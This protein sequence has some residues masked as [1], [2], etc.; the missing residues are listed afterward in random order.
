MSLMRLL[1]AGKSLVGMSDANSR[2]RMGKPGMMPKFGSGRNPFRSAAQ[3]KEGQGESVTKPVEPAVTPSSSQ[4]HI[5]MAEQKAQRTSPRR[6]L[7]F[8]SL[9]GAWIEK[10]KARF[11]RR[12]SDNQRAAIA[13]SPSGLMQ[14]ELSLDR[15]KVVRNDLSDTDFEITARE[16]AAPR[17]AVDAS[18]QEFRTA[19]KAAP[20][21]RR[22]YGPWRE[23]SGRLDELR[24]PARGAER[25]PASQPIAAGAMLSPSGAV[26]FA[27]V[28]R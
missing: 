9:F 2:Y 8:R 6:R 16:A 12:A 27:S 15:I 20:T 3:K 1:S 24:Q 19:M 11:G 26:W 7:V 21:A 25:S 17:P 4:P 5:S 10:L 13:P 23:L 14:G 18:S 28:Q 22:D